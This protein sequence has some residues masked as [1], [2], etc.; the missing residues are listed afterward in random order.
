MILLNDGLLD[1]ISFTKE[2]GLFV[3][4]AAALTGVALGG[5][6]V[7]VPALGFTAGG[8]AAA[9][10][11]AFLGGTIASGSIFATLQS[12]G[13]AGL[14]VSTQLDI[15]AGSAGLA[16]AHSVL[17]AVK[18]IRKSKDSDKKK[19]KGEDDDDDSEDDDG[20]VS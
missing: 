3:L 15:C 18:K 2:A 19:Q 5:V 4:K 10:Q 17:K 1:G 9:Y 11:S 6:A 8:I 7:A 20:A 12:V 16:G 14:A 13:A